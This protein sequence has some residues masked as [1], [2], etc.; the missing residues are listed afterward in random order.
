MPLLFLSGPL[1]SGP[2]THCYRT[3]CTASRCRHSCAFKPAAQAAATA[4][5]SSTATAP[6]SSDEAYYSAPPCPF[7][8]TA[9]NTQK[10][11]QNRLWGWFN[12]RSCVF[13]TVSGR[14]AMAE[15]VCYLLGSCQG[16]TETAKQAY[17]VK[18][19]SWRMVTLGTVCNHSSLCLQRNSSQ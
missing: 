18:W 3:L 11:A 14:T 5:P 16:T 1:T 6:P 17:G 9:F 10:D 8:P 7:P 15:V 13:Y 12:D 2:V 4:V 19:Q